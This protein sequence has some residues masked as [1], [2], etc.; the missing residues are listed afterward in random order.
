MGSEIACRHQR[1]VSFILPAR[2]LLAVDVQMR[3]ESSSQRASF[4]VGG[5]GRT[6]RAAWRESAG[7]PS[8][9]KSLGCWTHVRKASLGFG[10]IC[11]KEL[12]LL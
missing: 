1:H 6:D 4:L 12:K 7:S 5:V 11:F 2:L 9:P 10:A 3:P 8:L